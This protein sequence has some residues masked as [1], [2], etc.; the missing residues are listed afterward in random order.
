MTEF[1][2]LS[3]ADV[4]PMLDWLATRPRRRFALLFGR[5]CDAEQFRR[6][7]RFASACFARTG[8]SRVR[9]VNSCVSITN[10]LPRGPA[11]RRHVEATP[12]TEGAYFP[13][14]VAAEEWASRWAD[15][16][17][18]C[19]AWQ[20]AYSAGR[21]DWQG[22]KRAR[23]AERRVQ[24]SLLRCISGNPFRPAAI[25]LDWLECPGHAA[26]QLASTIAATDAFDRLPELA[27]A[28]REA[29]CDDA[30]LLAHCRGPGPH[31]RGCWAVE[32]LAGEAQGQVRVTGN[33]AIR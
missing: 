17:S 31:A 14:I 19:V 12:W 4:R 30:E 2:W 28:L 10:A 16:A 33:E 1:E 18:R 6:L 26:Q 29:G 8:E 7:S 23:A 25:D 21:L 20:R 15:A 13:L 27:D 24:A 22:F 32:L 5:P 9:T 11:R 3:C